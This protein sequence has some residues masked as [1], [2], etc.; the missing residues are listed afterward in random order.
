[1]FNLLIAVRQYVAQAD[2]LPP[3]HIG[4]LHTKRL[5]DAAGRLAQIDKQLFSRQTKNPVRQKRFKTLVRK[6]STE[7]LHKLEHIGQMRRCA[8]N[9]HSKTGSNCGSIALRR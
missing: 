2:H 7:L 3:G 5:V 8:V 9:R 4:H 1:M 6:Q